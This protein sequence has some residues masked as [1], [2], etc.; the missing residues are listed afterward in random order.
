MDSIGDI[1]KPI[2]LVIPNLAGTA[3]LKPDIGTAIISGAKLWIRVSATAWEV[4]TSA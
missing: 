2:A 3:A 1:V 4:V